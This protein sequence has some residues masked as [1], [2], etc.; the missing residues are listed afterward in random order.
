MINL[1][2]TL[3]LILTYS[4]ITFAT[5][6]GGLSTQGGTPPSE[7]VHDGFY[8]YWWTDGGANATYTNKANGQFSIEWGTGGNVFGGKGWRPGTA[9]RIINYSATLATTGNSYLSVY[10]WT[11]SPLVEYYVLDNYGTYNPTSATTIRGNVTVD[12][13]VYDILANTRVL[14]TPINGTSILR[15]YWS[16]RRDKR[17][18]GSVNL[19]AHFRAWEELGMKVGTHTWQIVA[20]E[21]YFSSGTCDVMVNSGDS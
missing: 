6:L 21:G 15:Q 10:G 18:S 14:M 17:T 5:L 8:H 12:G 13:S 9:N 19:G 4:R 16:V 2:W 1:A 7:G 11:Q 20:C 3:I